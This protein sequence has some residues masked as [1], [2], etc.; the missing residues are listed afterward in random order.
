MHATAQTGDR[1]YGGKL[2]ITDDPQFAVAGVDFIHTDVWVSRGESKD[3]W[4]ERIK[5]LTP[6]QVNAKLMKAAKNPR[7]KFMHCLPTFH[8]L[9][10]KVGE[11]IHEHFGLTAMEVSED[12][13]E[14]RN[15]RCLRAGRESHAHDQGHSG[16]HF[17]RLSP[18]ASWWRS[19]ETRCCAAASR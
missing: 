12:V 3:V 6:Y 2:T 4:D 19:E 9:E 7:V 15:E 16:R 10:T 17:G 13:F 14:I 11:D 5:L 18:C 8:N 1:Q